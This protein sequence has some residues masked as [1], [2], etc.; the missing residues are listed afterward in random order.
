MVIIIIIG[1]GGRRR[2][3]RR[4]R[5]RRK[6]ERNEESESNVCSLRRPAFKCTYIYNNSVN[7][8]RRTQD[9]SLR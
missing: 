1:G 2:R 4:R 6:K 5:R 9:S 7:T 8:S 3:G